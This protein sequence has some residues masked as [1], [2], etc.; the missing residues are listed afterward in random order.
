MTYINTILPNEA[1]GKLLEIYQL[2][3]KSRGKVADLYIA[4]SLNPESIQN[5]LDLYMTLMYGK[6]PL[7]RTQR[8][9]MAV[10][11]SVQ[12]QCNY[13]IE[14]HR[15]A[16]EHF[17]RDPKK[18]KILIRDFTDEKLNLSKKD[19]LLCK[20]AKEMTLFP[21]GDFENLLEQLKT[22]GLDEKGTLDAVLIISYFNFVNRMINTLGVGLE[23]DSGGYSYD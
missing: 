4:Q 5:H 13:C 11:V 22:T 10:V 20:L 19:L 18:T 12:N 14:H 6:S 21:G 9:M 17:W 2:I 3:E 7:K 15:I 8:E 23:A 1:K 16:L